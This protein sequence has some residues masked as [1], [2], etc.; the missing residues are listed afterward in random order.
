M[1]RSGEITLCEIDRAVLFCI[2]SAQGPRLHEAGTGGLGAA[3][4]AEVGRPW[5]CLG[6]CPLWAVALPLPA[7]A[8]GFSGAFGQLLSAAL[9]AGRRGASTAVGGGYAAVKERRRL[10]RL[11]GMSRATFEF[12][13]RR[14]KI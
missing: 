10:A 14:P 2:A 6:R 12:L 3:L 1:F 9:P 13:R 8:A 7:I 11:C 5:A 4:G